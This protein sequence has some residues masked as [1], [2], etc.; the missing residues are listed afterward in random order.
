MFVFA[1]HFSMSSDSV[2]SFPAFLFSHRSFPACLSSCAG[3]GGG[4]AGREYELP[5]RQAVFCLEDCCQHGED[6]W[7]ETGERWDWQL[8]P[9]FIHPSIHPP[10]PPS[11]SPLYHA[12]T[13][14]L[15]LFPPERRYEEIFATTFTAKN[16]IATRSYHMEQHMKF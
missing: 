7:G 16:R 9:A 1:A 3:G 10:T 13:K 5:G 4:C 8:Q 14:I 2:T 6:G 15:G 12:S 11:H